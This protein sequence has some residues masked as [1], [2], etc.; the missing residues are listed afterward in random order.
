[1]QIW[2]VRHAIAAQR[3]E[4]QGADVERPLTDKGRKRFR[5][6]ADW[7]A[8]SAP[9]IRKIVTS[10]LLRAAQTANLLRKGMGLRKADVTISDVLA[11]G[12]S[13]DKI[14]EL[15]GQLSLEIVAFVGHEPDFSRALGAFVGGGR[16][17]FGKGAV[18]AIEFPEGPQLSRGTLQWFVGPK[19]QV[20]MKK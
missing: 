8:E 12:A 13:P 16:F 19:F 9:P 7:L 5:A 3:D 14:L 4:F 11:P 2:L 20:A 6:F 10:P 18:A 17:E 15:A 1:M